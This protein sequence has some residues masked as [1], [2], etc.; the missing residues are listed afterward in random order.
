VARWTRSKSRHHAGEILIAGEGTQQLAQVS[1]APQSLKHSMKVAAQQLR[2][3]NFL[4]GVSPRTTEHE[5]LKMYHKMDPKDS[6]GWEER[7]KEGTEPPKKVTKKEQLKQ[8]KHYKSFIEGELS[9]SP[10]EDSAKAKKMRSELKALL[11]RRAAL[12]KSINDEEDG[13]IASGKHPKDWTRSVKPDPAENEDIINRLTR[14]EDA[15]ATFH[16]WIAGQQAKAEGMTQDLS[17][18]SGGYAEKQGK[19]G[20]KA[21]SGGSKGGSKRVSEDDS[22]LIRSAEERYGDHRDSMMSIEQRAAYKVNRWTGGGYV[23]VY[24]MAQG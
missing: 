19:A 7:A 24:D 23:Q 8:I 2:M 21:S 20:K 5:V 16:S 9:T 6:T 18:E 13:V 14:R 1:D 3:S 10:T 15:K 11:A 17:E 22:D 12:Q 4:S